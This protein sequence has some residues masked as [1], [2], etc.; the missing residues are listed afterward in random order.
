[1][2]RF[3]PALSDDQTPTIK[4][5]DGALIEFRHGVDVGPGGMWLELTEEQ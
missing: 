1:M 2:C 5:H 4:F 3:I